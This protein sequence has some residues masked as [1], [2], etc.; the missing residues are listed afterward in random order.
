MKKSKAQIE[1]EKKFNKIAKKLH[2]EQACIPIEQPKSNIDSGASKSLKSNNLK[3]NESKISTKGKSNEYK[4]LKDIFN[5]E[6]EKEKKEVNPT[7]ISDSD[8]KNLYE[9]KLN[10]CFDSYLGKINISKNKDFLKTNSSSI[11]N[12]PKMIII[13]DVSGSMG[14]QV[15]RFIQKII[16]EILNNIYKSNSSYS[17][18]LITFSSF[19]DLN[20][21]EGNS[22]QISKYTDIYA[23]GA[24]YMA[25]AVDTFYEMIL[26]KKYENKIYR[27]LTLSDGEL[28][29]QE[30]TIESADKLKKL[31]QKENFVVNSQ[32]VRL[33]TG[34]E[35]DT[36]GLSSML[37][38]STIGKQ[39]MLDVDC[40]KLGDDE[41]SNLISDLYIN[42]GL[43]DSIVLESKLKDNCIQEEPWSSP[44]NLIYLFPGNN[45]FWINLKTPKDD[46]CKEI[47]NNFIIKFKD[48]TTSKIKCLLTEDISINNYQEL[49]K[50]KIDFYFKQLKVFKVVNTEESLSKMDK[51]IEFFNNLEENIFAKDSKPKSAAQFKL[52]ERTQTI[53]TLIKRRKISL[54][55]KMREIR[56]DD[57]INLLNSKQQAEYLREIDINDKTGKSLAK[58]ALGGGIDFDD[59]VRKEVIQ[60]A[61]HIHELDSVD[62]SKLTPSF[63]STCNTLDGIRAVSTFYKEA[64]KDNIFEETTANDIIKIINIVGVAANALIGNFPDPMTYRLKTLYPGTFI[65]LSDIL[66]AYGVNGG[67]NLK[68][69]G[70]QNEI[71][72]TIPYFEDERIEK[73]LM[74]YS[75]KLLEYSASI[76]MRRILAEIPYTHEYTILSGLWAMIPILLKDKKEINI[77]I[78]V[79]LC[80]GYLISAGDHFKYVLELLENQ[81]EI[82]KDGLS[83]YIANNGITNMISPILMYLKNEKGKEV[84]EMMK[85]IV[86]ATYQFEIYQFTK[87]NVK[88]QKTDNPEKYIREVLIDLLKIDLEKDKTLIP[89]LFEEIPENPVFS[90]K[91]EINEKKFKEI[92][93]KIWWADY[94]IITPLFLK[95]SL[96]KDPVSEFKSIEIDNIT[97]EIIR[98]RLG[99]NYSSKLFK[100]FCIVQAYLQYEQAD[101]IDTENKKMKI[102]DLG[103]K[104]KAEKY[105][106]DFIQSLHKEKYEIGLKEREKKENNILAELLVDKLV[107][108]KDLSEFNNLLKNGIK[109][110]IKEYKLIDHASLGFDVLI[111]NISKVDNNIPYR[112]EKI[113]ILL[114]GKDE[115]ENQIWNES[116]KIKSLKTYYPLKNVLKPEEWNDLI[117]TMK[118]RG[119][120]IYRTNKNRQGHDNS[121]LSYWAMGFNS[122]QEMMSC[123]SKEEFE[124]YSIEH[125][126]C[127]GFYKGQYTIM[128]RCDKGMGITQKRKEKHSQSQNIIRGNGIFRGRENRGN[129]GYRRYR[130]YRGRGGK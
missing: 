21:Y 10:K 69:I 92:M 104:D 11:S 24:T 127:C 3:S 117:K 35:P 4:G 56:N 7:K 51:I 66:I 2:G 44:N 57:K 121:H 15:E 120:H 49:I 48:N 83:I 59:I 38:L 70:T 30:K 54:T 13:L 26:S 108:S 73:F 67:Q 6:K 86:R 79:E 33:I 58:R 91:F 65:S 122:I 1:Y 84:D 29:D 105:V 89:E 52:Y 19:G 12:T 95:A 113:Y 111:K 77:K 32:S 130:R 75:P 36:R 78:F 125:A 55:N 42:D 53:K 103:L 5:E 82:D 118:K 40:N 99:I 129:R 60:I 109:K 123:V 76:G 18:C 17:V 68:E 72:T 107:N 9:L 8:Y 16:P 100:L 87:K 116:N 119:I 61:N 98:E 50:D 71:I 115:K 39:M 85:R 37:Q 22:E 64:I 106:K 124:K 14:E 25:Q 90:D 97:E 96:S 28:H 93:G 112:K 34:F 31:L 45:T 63:Y 46:I 94:I 74:K 27:I 80:K 41:I 81:K 126:N 114:T 88:T 47:E 110:G 20:V 62:E 102:I 23:N 101:R 128:R 43:G